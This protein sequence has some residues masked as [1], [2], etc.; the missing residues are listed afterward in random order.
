MR[1]EVSVLTALAT[2]TIFTLSACTAPEP[3]VDRNKFVRTLPIDCSVL[4]EFL[5]SD[6]SRLLRY[7]YSD[8]RFFVTDDRDSLCGRAAQRELEP[9]LEGAT[10]AALRYNLDFFTKGKSET[11]DHFVSDLF[12]KRTGDATKDSERNLRLSP[13]T[14]G[15]AYLAEGNG[16]VMLSTRLYVL[17]AVAQKEIGFI[18]SGANREKQTLVFADSAKLRK[19]VDMICIPTTLDD[20]NNRLWMHSNLTAAS[21]ALLLN[22]SESSYHES[23]D[24]SE[25]SLNLVLSQL[26]KIKAAIEAEKKGA[27]FD[28]SILA[29]QSYKLSG[30]DEVNLSPGAVWGYVAADEPGR[31]LLEV[32]PGAAAAGRAF[33]W[34]ESGSRKLSVMV[35]YSDAKSKD[36]ESKLDAK[37]GNSAERLRYFFAL[38]WVLPGDG[39]ARPENFSLKVSFVPLEEG[40]MPKVLFFRPAVE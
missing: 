1:L 38:P 12:S 4:S 29:G 10:V 15:G 40:H 8:A 32:M 19:G 23:R 39:D 16:S 7:L 18:G 11:S 30:H 33:N 6:R 2:F 24:A 13:S 21:R 26:R 14:A 31:V 17:N 36:N 20:K 5:E 35:G 28:L 3:I 34:G 9:Q 37:A 22:I 25:R 27:S